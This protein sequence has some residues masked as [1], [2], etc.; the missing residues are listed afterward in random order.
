MHIKSIAAALTAALLLGSAAEAADLIIEPPVVIDEAYDW[1]GPYV[2][3]HAGYLSGRV[4]IDYEDL[5][6]E[7]DLAGFLGGFYGGYN[8]QA[9]GIVFGVEGDVGFGS[10]SGD[11]GSAPPQPVIAYEYDLIWNAHLRGRI[12]LPVD[13][14]L[15]YLAGGLAVASHTLTVIELQYEGGGTQVHVGWT[16]GFG[17]EIVVADNIVLRAEYLYDDYG[18]KTYTTEVPDDE[19]EVGI[20]AHTVRAG[21]AVTF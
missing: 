19:Y 21:I 6:T 3:V 7:G 1:T 14:A 17:A 5:A 15:F 4:D 13:Q 10:V 16:A 8:F 9:D 2:G 20:T 11:G 12:G 18:T